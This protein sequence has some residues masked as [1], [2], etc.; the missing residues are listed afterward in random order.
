MTARPAV[1]VM[2]VCPVEGIARPC[3]ER[4]PRHARQT[5]N[6]LILNRVTFIGHM[7]RR[8]FMICA[9][10]TSGS[11]STSHSTCTA[12]RKDKFLAFKRS[13]Q[14]CTEID[15]NSFLFVRHF[16]RESRQL[17]IPDESHIMR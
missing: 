4:A 13:D 12:L 16:R 5:I 8:P 3:K 6:G 15:N 2:P 7:D 17:I 10:L 14:L 11:V 1:I 9:E